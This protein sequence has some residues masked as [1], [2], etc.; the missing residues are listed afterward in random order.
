MLHFFFR[1]GRAGAPSKRLSKGV[2]KPARKVPACLGARPRNGPHHVT[3]LPLSRKCCKKESR[4]I[5]ATQ[6]K[7]FQKIHSAEEKSREVKNKNVEVCLSLTVAGVRTPPGS[8]KPVARSPPKAGSCLPTLPVVIC[9]ISVILLKI[10]L[11]LIC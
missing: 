3:S 8:A 11:T 9:E 6:P 5:R 4:R 2:P 7:R 10:S 1:T